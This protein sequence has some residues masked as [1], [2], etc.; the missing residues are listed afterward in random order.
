MYGA[1]LKGTRTGMA[2]QALA[3]VVRLVEPDVF[4]RWRFSEVIHID[5]SKPAKLGLDSAEHRI[6]RVARVAGFV[7]RDAMILK[8]R[9]GQV[10]RIVHAQALSIRLHDVARKAR[11]RTLGIF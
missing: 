3:I 4:R 8:V 1:F 11:P 9:R 2:V 7:R 5:M 6:I 10:L